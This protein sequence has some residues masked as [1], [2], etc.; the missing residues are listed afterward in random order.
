[1]RI[2]RSIMLA[3]LFFLGRTEHSIAQNEPV[4]TRILFIFDASNSMNAPWM[5]SN[6]IET[7]RRVMGETLD[8]LKGIP[9]LELALRIYGHQTPLLPN[10]QDCNDTKLEVSFGGN[11]AEA[12][13]KWIQYVVPK[14]TTPIARSLEKSGDDFPACDHCRNIIILITD[15]IEACDEDPC[16]IARAL[17]SKGIAVKPFIIG[18]GMN[19]DYLKA[20]ECIGNVY[21]A[22]SPEA[23]KTII[24]VVISEALNNTT[25]QIN[26]NDINGKPT[27]TNVSYTLYDQRTGV[28][29]Y[30]YVHTLNQWGNPDTLS[31]DPLL[32]Y[33]LVVHTIPQVVKTDIRLIPQ[34]HNVISVDAPRGYIETKIL[35]YGKTKQNPACIIRRAGEMN[36]L[37]VQH[38]PEKQKYI[39]GEYDLEILTLPRIYMEGVKVSQSISTKI[40]IPEAGVLDLTTNVTGY[41]AIFVMEKGEMIW[42]CDLKEDQKKQFFELQPGKYKIVYRNKN[43]KRTLYSIEKD[44]QITSGKTTAIAI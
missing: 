43:S 37:N 10:Q 26:L 21:D 40:E 39:V 4:L 42:V 14:G 32:T 28:V 18:V 33:K 29:K 8:S 34:Q 30:N 25:A 24:N 27:E 41:G 1:M 35:T 13:K 17:K 5:G 12:V 3:I 11:N 7:A 16:A 31:L 19:M 15:G 44:I 6:R 2:F 20:L 22:N 23:F 9:N 38:F 36:T